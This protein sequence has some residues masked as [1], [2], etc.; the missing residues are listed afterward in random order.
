MRQ[1]DLFGLADM[2]A[3]YP[4]VPG[5]KGRETSVAAAQAIAPRAP[6]LRERVLAE[7]RRRPGT[8][9]DIARRIKEPVMNVRPRFSEL[10]SMGLLEDSGKRGKAMGG[11]KAIVWRCAT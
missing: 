7:I 5:A 8:P 3:A 6:T 1:T 2:P 9:E 11:R 4:E 10:S